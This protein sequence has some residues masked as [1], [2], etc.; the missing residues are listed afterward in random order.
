MLVRN[1]MHAQ[2]ADSDEEIEMSTADKDKM[3]KCPMSLTWLEDPVACS[4]G[5]VFSRALVENHFRQVTPVWRT[6][7][8]HF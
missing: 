5:H 1:K 7:V 8:H 4:Q 6:V 2:V 3:L